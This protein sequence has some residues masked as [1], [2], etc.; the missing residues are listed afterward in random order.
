ML[1]Q[2]EFDLGVAAIAALLPGTGS[3]RRADMVE[4]A[5]HDV[6]EPPP[7][8]CLE[9]GDSSFKQVPHVVEFV[10]VPQVGPAVLRF[11]AEIPAVQIAIR[12]LGRPKIVDD[13]LDLRFDFGVAAMG[14]RIAGRLDPFAHIAVPEDLH[15]KT[16]GMARDNQGGG[17]FGSRR[18]SRIVI[19]VSLA[20]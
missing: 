12:R 15:R 10:V 2:R 9:V 14:K 20:C 6:Q 18:L 13:R 1:D 3:E 19:S 16:V 8:G 5:F 4:T 11:A 17:G 7:P